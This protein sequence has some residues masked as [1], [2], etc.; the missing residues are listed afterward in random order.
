MKLPS[1]KELERYRKI[2]YSEIV[3]NAI[4]WGRGILMDG[5]PAGWTVDLREAIL[6]PELAHV[7]SQLF[8]PLI[9][10]YRP[11]YVAGMTVAAGCLV[12]QLVLL[13]H[14]RGVPVKGLYIRREPKGDGMQRQIE[15]QLRENSKVLLLDDIINS[16]DVALKCIEQLVKHRCIPVALA[17][18]L[19]FQNSGEHD[20][21]KLGIPLHH[22]FTL[23]DINM[24]PPAGQED[25]TMFL[26]VWKAGPVNSGAYYAPKSGPVSGEGRIFLGS[27]RGYFISLHSNGFP[28]WFF[29]VRETYRGIQV[30]PVYRKG[31]VY[32]GAYDGYTYCLK[33]SSGK[34]MWK[35]KWGDWVGC[36]SPAFAPS[37]DLFFIGIEYGS[38]G[39]DLC[40][41]NGIDGTLK[42]RFKTGEY[43]T[44]A[45]GINSNTN[46]VFVGSLDKTVY[47]LDLHEGTEK[48]RFLTDGDIKGGITT[49]YTT[50]YCYFTSY[51]GHLY[52]L[53]NTGETVWKR[54][55]GHWL[56]S[57]PAVSND[58]VLIGTEAD[59]IFSLNKMTGKIIW[60]RCMSDEWK[61]CA[62]PVIKHG[63]VYAG[64]YGGTVYVMSLYDGSIL[65]SFKTGGPV[66]A[67]CGIFPSRKIRV[68]KPVLKQGKLKKN[69]FNVH[70][71]RLYYPG[72]GGLTHIFNS[73]A[74]RL[75]WSV[76]SLQK[77]IPSY[78]NTLVASSNDGYIYCFVEI[79]R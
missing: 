20:I 18:I 3:D 32:F 48:W 60:K 2:L 63:R 28:D 64:S 55:L 43:V 19:N 73:D 47:A 11:D 50:D 54:K 12:S 36:S 17:V 71:D 65:W 31:R 6:T 66:M 46:T 49:D 78:S 22:I 79:Y 33:A 9:D 24:K 53:N 77:E 61:M 38:H 14:I 13:S 30:T 72:P 4:K 34:V 15:G 56:Y 8:M 25:N 26:P 62:Y 21:K 16:S 39:G 51:D 68:D 57:R 29:P 75:L 7:I 74:T 10:R 35:Q 70:G 59:Y 42:W 5:S 37:E 23:G 27:D 58:M 45:P 67:P 1:E 41:F 44:C 52:C 76:Y 40:A 69:T